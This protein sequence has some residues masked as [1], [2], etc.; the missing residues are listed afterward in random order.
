MLQEEKILS[1]PKAAV[2]KKK[3][4]K[5]E[6]A[7]GRFCTRVRI[8]G[9][10]TPKFFYGATKKEADQKAAE[11]RE[12][13]KQGMKAIEYDITVEQWCSTWLKAEKSDK[14]YNTQKGYAH[15]IDIINQQIGKMMVREVREIHL[16]KILNGRA[17]MSKSQI[18]KLCNTIQQVF[19][20]ARKNRII[21]VDPSID[22]KKPKG[23]YKGHR[24]LEPWEINLLLTNYSIHPAGLWAITMM[25]AGLRRGEVLALSYDNLKF[26]EEIIQVRTGIHFENGKAVDS[27]T[28][29][30]VAGIRNVPMLEPLTTILKNDFEM[31]PRQQLAITTKGKTITENSFR[32]QWQT[33]MRRLTNIASGY[34]CDKIPPKNEKKKALYLASLKK[35]HFTPHDLRY[36]YAT[37]LYDSGVDEKTA[38][39]YLGH[40]SPQMTRDLYASLTAERKAQSDENLAAY[41]KRFTSPDSQF[42]SHECE[43]HEQKN[44]KEKTDI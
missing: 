44:K 28:T 35:V 32:R 30:T 23:K 31:H 27:G 33:L 1:F 4:R 13:M 39:R 11:F 10:K 40:T 26:D 14:A 38:Q 34:D 29:K 20:S 36:T 6:R 16:V 41:F 22:L 42:D 7:D 9:Q 24:A 25:L 37:I 8:K 12:L 17:G 21:I 15:Q 2:P 18:D 3:L 5:N 19:R 43:K